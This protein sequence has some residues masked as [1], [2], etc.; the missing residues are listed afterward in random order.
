[1]FKAV[2]C[3]KCGANIT[4][5]D[6][7]QMLEN[8]ETLLK[9]KEFGKAEKEFKEMIASYPAKVEGYMG[10][11]RAYTFDFEEDNLYARHDIERVVNQFER[12][13]DAENKEAE[14]FIEKAKV[15]CKR[16]E[17]LYEIN[18][19]KDK[20]LARGKLRNKFLKFFVF[21]MVIFAGIAGA[22]K[23][24]VIETDSCMLLMK[25][26]LPIVVIVILVWMILGV[27]RKSMLKKIIEKEKNI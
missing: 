1:M 12:V 11:I 7:D 6:F 23:F 20:Y 25:V 9:M 16:A 18:M 4:I 22:Y 27:M 10:L 14:E 5:K 8:G 17:S 13:L 21:M 3:P 2:D 19:D 26:Y 24:G 15:Y